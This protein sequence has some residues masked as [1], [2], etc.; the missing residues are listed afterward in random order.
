M[1]ETPTYNA[2]SHARLTLHS[3]PHPVFPLLN[4]PE[5]GVSL[6]LHHK[7]CRGQVC[8]QAV[9][10]RTCSWYFANTHIQEA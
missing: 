7:H 3:F 6:F 9:G 8:W 10:E 4:H 1:H 5:L 2:P